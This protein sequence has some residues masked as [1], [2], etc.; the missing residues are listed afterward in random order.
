MVTGDVVPVIRYGQRWFL[1][2]NPTKEMTDLE[3]RIYEALRSD[4]TIRSM[5]IVIPEV[6]QEDDTSFLVM[7]AG[8]TFADILNSPAHDRL[9]NDHVLYRSIEVR[10]AVNAVV[11]QIL[12]VD[13]KVYLA[14]TQRKALLQKAQQ[15][16]SEV[17][18]ADVTAHLWAYRMMNALGISDHKFRDI[19]TE[20]IGKRI[21]AML[22]KYGMY[23]TDNFSRNIV[24]GS[25]GSIIPFDFNSIRYGLRQFDDASIA[26]LYIYAG[27]LAVNAEQED[28]PIVMRKLQ[29]VQGLSAD[30]DYDHAFFIANI[31]ANGI[32]A[33]YRTK[34]II[35]RANGLRKLTRLNTRDEAEE[36]LQFKRAHDEIEYYQ[37]AVVASLWGSNPIV[38]LGYELDK[39]RYI[40]STISSH[41]FG[42]RVCVLSSL[43]EHVRGV[44]EVYSQL[45]AEQIR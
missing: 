12:T 2:R 26:G 1:K 3:L 34:E 39:L 4:N 40:V 25:D 15:L 36:Y 22:P 44:G 18:E 35:E 17:T 41:T 6:E 20:V 7:D 21:D 5:N 42:K 9:A 13:D 23:C 32:I 37:S 8:T 14:V 33:G 24:V 28:R 38:T 10:A 31:H 45:R 19:Y 16:S 30:E 43:P 29:E 27:E 11:N